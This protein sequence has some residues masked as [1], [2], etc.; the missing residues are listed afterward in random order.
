MLSPLWEITRTLN[1]K[2]MVL[3]SHMPAL[4]GFDEFHVA[5]EVL[6]NS[7]EEL[8]KAASE[9][10]IVTQISHFEYEREWERE[11]VLQHEVLRYLTKKGPTR[12]DDLFLHFAQYAPG[13]IAPALRH[14]AQWMH[15]SLEGGDIVK[16]TASGTARLSA[17]YQR[18]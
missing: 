4:L 17:G 8:L 15:I 1:S 9:E 12:W 14:L 3:A 11:R 18:P 7:K 13:K 6:M 10:T 16:V 2:G 5:S